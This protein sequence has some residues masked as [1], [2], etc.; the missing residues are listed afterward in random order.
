MSHTLN[1]KRIA[2][3]ISIS[4]MLHPTYLFPSVLCAPALTPNLLCWWS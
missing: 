4:H 3:T 1:Q 2:Q